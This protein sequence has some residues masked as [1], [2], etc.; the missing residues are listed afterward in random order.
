MRSPVG[1]VTFYEIAVELQCIL[2]VDRLKEAMLSTIENRHF[3]IDLPAGLTTVCM[4]VVL[5]SAVRDYLR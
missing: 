4:Y 5:Y 1:N 2:G 3:P